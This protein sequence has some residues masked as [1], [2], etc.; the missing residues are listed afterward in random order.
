VT[1]PEG[2]VASALTASANRQSKLLARGEGQKAQPWQIDSLGY[3]DQLGVVRY[4]SMFWARALTQIRWY[5]AEKD[6]NG[7]LR[8]TE[9][10]RA[11]AI[12]A[13]VHDPQGGRSAM[14]QAYGQLRFL[15]G[16]CYLVWTMPE[17][18]EEESW[19]ILSVVE[20]RQEGS[21]IRDGIRVPTYRRISAPG[22]TA[23][24]LTEATPDDFEPMPGNVM[25][26]RM[27]RRHP[28]YSLQADAPM[29]SVLAE[30]EEIVRATQ[31]IN[32]RLI[33]RM[34]A[35]GVFAIPKSW[36][37]TPVNAPAGAD[38]PRENPFQRKLTDA[39]MT[40][41]SNPGSAE[42]VVPIVIAVPDESAD[43][44]EHYR[45][46]EPGEEIR[47]IALRDSAIDRFG[48]GV[49]MPPEKLK[50]LG[51]SNHWN[52]WMLDEEGWAHIAPVAQEFADDMTGA[53]L[54]PSCEAENIEGDFVV[55][56]DA[57]EFLTN[58]DSFA[59]A[60]DM[61]D[62]RVVGKAYLR[63]AG[64]ANDTDAPSDEELEEML[65]VATRKPVD[66]EGGAIDEDSADDDSAGDGPPTGEDTE[67]EAPELPESANGNA[68]VILQ[69]RVL[70]A[71]EA[72]IE[73]MR[74]R[75][76]S[77]LRSHVQGN[78]AHCAEL[79]R[80]EPNE[81]VAV[82]LGAETLAEVAPGIDAIVRG[83]ATSFTRTLV[84]W[85]V[86]EA[87]ATALTELLEAHVI[88]TIAEESPS[89]P[90]GFGARLTGI[91]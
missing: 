44:G 38:N 16:E 21:T 36:T 23:K 80:G 79:I 88:A 28:A 9:N 15:N 62:R 87:K 26:W 81:R 90:A 86:S 85:G 29:R 74:A 45:F 70:G 50:G 11:Q 10:E 42:A 73:S 55:A 91:I 2:K 12:L 67:R 49:D 30:C 13:R 58:P 34:A 51:E 60:K 40:A 75:A 14:M 78:C 46:W 54:L 66:V 61:Y 33:S 5:V 24:E 76:G 8:E 17:D 48:I 32:A 52:A 39:M 41:I 35:A 37:Q 19:E 84:K 18:G 59:D 53:Y 89:P 69:Y 64:G 57:A 71:A 68:S 31:A 63:N 6:E 3:Y 47:E 72:E 83:S 65:L 7:E 22:L 77:R 27:W 56:Y 1:G 43:K 20:L 4:A 82:V 25:V